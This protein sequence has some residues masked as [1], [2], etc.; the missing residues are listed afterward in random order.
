MKT[1]AML[2]WADGSRSTHESMTQYDGSVPVTIPRWRAPRALLFED[3]DL[4]FL[5][6]DSPYYL[7]G[8]T[9]HTFKWDA[10]AGAWFERK[11]PRTARDDWQDVLFAWVKAGARAGERPPLAKGVCGP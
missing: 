3:S 11:R 1:T 5:L 10:A 8:L 2:V 7:R 9:E 6:P 4:S